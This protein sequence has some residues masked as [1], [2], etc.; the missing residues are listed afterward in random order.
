MVFYPNPAYQKLNGFTP[1]KLNTSPPPSDIHMSVVTLY[2][3]T[4]SIGQIFKENA[5]YL[6]FLFSK[7][8]KTKAKCLLIML[9]LTF[10]TPITAPR[11]IPVQMEATVLMDST[12]TA[13]VVLLAM[14]DRDA[15]Q[16][17]AMDKN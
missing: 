2:N 17:S 12:L 9:C 10:Q 1:N 5:V 4:I 13:V 14:R 16:V 8:A 7:L 15:K 11:T 3:Y 6:V